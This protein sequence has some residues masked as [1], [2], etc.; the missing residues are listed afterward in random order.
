MLPKEFTARME[1]L[2]GD[3]FPAF[4]KSLDEP[5]HR[6]LRLGRKM[7][8]AAFEKGYGAQS[9]VPYAADAYYCDDEKPGRHP[10]HAA[11]V[12]Y[13]QDP[14]AMA[15][16]AGVP[17]LE[18]KLCLDLCAAPG[19]KTTQ[20]SALVGER[21][22]V[23]AN[24]IV[25]ARCRILQGNLER[26]GCRNTALTNLD[27]KSLAK[28][29]PDFFDFIAVDAPCSGEGMFRKYEVASTEWSLQNVTLCAERQAEILDEA[30]KMLAENG[31]ILY[32]TCTFSPEENEL[33]VDAFLTRHPDFRLL[34]LAGE[35]LSYT[36]EGYIPP[37][38]VHKTSLSLCRR[39]YPHLARGEGQFFALLGKT[40]GKTRRP[41]PT[42]PKW[43]AEEKRLLDAF[44][45][46][47]LS[48]PDGVGLYRHGDTPYLSSCPM[49]LPPHGVFAPGV[50]LGS[51]ERGR[52]EPHHQLFSAYGE[53]FKRQLNLTND[54]P[55]LPHYLA[56][57]VIPAEGCENGYAALRVDGAPLGG[58]KIVDGVAKNHYPKGLRV[59]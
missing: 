32:S 43:T 48:L 10:Y 30:A 35:V 40:G 22:F 21:G 46:K 59:R 20:L 50:L 37:D 56:G 6:A 25:T 33:T 9:P 54:D 53:H 13:V 1:R 7:R 19:G 15:S 28:F 36:A 55:R 12:Y 14:G 42:A 58:V 23:L 2:L 27:P 52:I 8:P 11:G 29:Y 24:E 47:E 34:P 45:K 17:N 5:P 4:L 38:A 16:L 39:F 31:R 41:A 3:G 26:L 51:F 57:E 18:G 44:F 49:P